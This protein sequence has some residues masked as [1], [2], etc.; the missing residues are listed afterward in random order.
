MESRI[1]GVA[2]RARLLAI[3][4]GA[5]VVIAAP[6]NAAAS[7]VTVSDV[8]Q[9]SAP[10]VVGQAP[11][12]GSVSGSCGTPFT[13]ESD[14]PVGSWPALG[15]SWGATLDVAGG[16][17]L[18]LTF[19]AAVS[20]VSVASTTNYPPGLRNP[21]G[22]GVANRDVIA[23]TPAVATADPTVWN[24][25]LPALDVTAMSGFTFS[26][27]ASDGS[28]TY[29]FPLTIRSPRYAD[30][31]TRCGPAYY[32]TGNGQYLCLNEP[33]GHPPVVTTQPPPT[34]ASLH[35]AT[36][37]HDVLHLEL[38]VPAAG[39]LR[40]SIVLPHRRPEVVIRHP[41]SAGRFSVA[42][43]LRGVRFSKAHHRLTL[44]MALHARVRSYTRTQ[45]V[46]VSY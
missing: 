17:R 14:C 12:P 20:A 28:G 13:L 29:D 39:T 26:V 40:I 3:A 11:V 18:V 6:A 8:G 31:S 30:E 42:L 43:R 15:G 32:S 16:D 41:R 21:S 33:K 5:F 4:V 46:S 36:F 10:V 1:R 2:W 37:R 34:L 19:S 7:G 44:R 23:A 22:T 35:G 24:V 9:V 25:V 27:V 45:A 38:S